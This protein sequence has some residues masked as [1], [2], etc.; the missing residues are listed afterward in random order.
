MLAAPERKCHEQQVHTATLAAAVARNTEEQQRQTRD[1]QQTQ[2]NA[3]A[4]AAAT[5]TTQAP[6]PQY[7]GYPQGFNP[8]QPMPHLNM[9]PQHSNMPPPPPPYQPQLSQPAGGVYQQN[10]TRA[11]GTGSEVIP[12]RNPM[13]GSYYL[14]PEDFARSRI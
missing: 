1:L 4:L 9:L 2:A 10:G 8:S 3:T 13:D 6:L 12:L 5:A 11:A 14:N 7:P